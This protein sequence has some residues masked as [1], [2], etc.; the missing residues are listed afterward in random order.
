MSVVI[1]QLKKNRPNLTKSSLTSYESTVRTLFKNL[2]G[3]GDMVQFFISNP[4]KVIKYLDTFTPLKRKLRLA[5]LVSLTSHDPKVAEKYQKMMIHDIKTTD[6]ELEEQRKTPT[7]KENWISQDEVMK[8]HNN[9][10]DQTA[11]L[12]KKASLTPKEKVL[13]QDYLIL[14]LYVLNPPRRIQDYTYMVLGTPSST[15]ENYISKKKFHFVKYKTAKKYGEQ[16]VDINPKL[17]YIIQKWKKLNP[18]QKWL[19]VGENGEQMSTPTLTMR[20]NKIF[21]G[22]KISVNMLRHIYITDEVLKDAPALKELQK[23]AEAMGHNVE[24]QM[25]YRKVD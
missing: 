20:L 19:L 18:D 23:K 11:Y 9:L 13:F 3:D 22:R 14:S 1:E 4:D 6:V 24:T 25:L 2:D 8:I 7:Q 17:A 10:R 12:F 15:E 21:G 5:C 16:V